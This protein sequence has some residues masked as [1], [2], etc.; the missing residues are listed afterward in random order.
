MNKSFKI[1]ISRLDFEKLD[2]ESS[3]EFIKNSEGVMVLKGKKLTGKWITS[4]ASKINEFE[5][6]SFL[7]IGKCQ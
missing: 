4:I 1:A 3:N 6:T 2:E 5:G 7:M